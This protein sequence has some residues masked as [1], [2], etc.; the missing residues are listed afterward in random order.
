MEARVPPDAGP[1]PH[2]QNREEEA[3]YVIQGSLVFLAGSTEVTVSSGTFLN[4]PKG[5]KHRF[6]NASDGDAELL[7]WFAPAGIEGL[8]RELAAHPEQITEIGRK[9]GTVY[10][11]DE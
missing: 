2:I 7:I 11:L 8:F 4:V 9:Y 1:P 5:T 6:H 10:F 3:F